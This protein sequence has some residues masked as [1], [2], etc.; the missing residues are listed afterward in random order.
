M[1]FVN[2]M[3]EEDERKE[4]VLDY[5]SKGIR[6]KFIGGTIDDE[7]DVRLF[8]YANVLNKNK[9]T[10]ITV[11]VDVVRRIFKFTITTTPLYAMLPLASRS[12][13]LPERLPQL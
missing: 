8:N 10:L 11:C 1:G 5:P 13:T 9:P 3:L 4:Y 6:G 2:R 7:N 12:S